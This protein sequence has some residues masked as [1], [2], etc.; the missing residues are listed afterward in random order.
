LVAHGVGA[1]DVVAILSHNS[2]E[3]IEVMLACVRLRAIFLPLNWRLTSSEL[4]YIVKD[5]GP[6]LLLHDADHA[7]STAELAHLVGSTASTD[8]V[9]PGG[10]VPD[11][12][13][14]SLDEVAAIMYTSGTTGRPKGALITHAMTFWHAVNI[15]PEAR[16]T[17]DTVHLAVLPFFHTGGL[18][19]YVNPVLHAGGTVVVVSRFDVE[20]ALDLLSDPALGVTHIFAV[21]TIYQA[22]ADS[23]GFAA[24]DLTRLRMAGVG[25]AAAPVSLL[26]EWRERDVLLAQGWGMTEGGPSGAVVDVDDPQTPLGSIGKPLLH[27]DTRIVD[28][29][30]SEVGPDQVGELWIKGPS[31]TPG[32]WRNQKATEEAFIDGWF[33]TGDAVRR[34]RSGY[35]FIVDRW[36]DM[37]ISGGENVYPAEVE[38]TIVELDGVASVAVVGVPDERWGEVGA[39]FVVL[40]VGATV[41]GEQVIAH[42]RRHLAKFKVPRQVEIVADLPMTGSGKIQKRMLV[43]R[44]T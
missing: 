16:I 7:V 12:R 24:A 37:Y 10:P 34:D 9:D 44:V 42:C 39:A 40:A 23:P 41:N 25:G 22:L 15:T 17:P 28:I 20:Q 30:G 4:T 18:N 14:P 8:V 32:Y 36:K 29:E 2:L 6:R 11:G 43:E 21:P 1:G 38:A 31:V 13:P 26:E 5:A 33:R 3:Y 27:I 35:L 19:L